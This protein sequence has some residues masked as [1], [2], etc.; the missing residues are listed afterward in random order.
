M[1]DN[2]TVL[3]QQILKSVTYL[4]RIKCFQQTLK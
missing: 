4:P 2:K 1:D 3:V